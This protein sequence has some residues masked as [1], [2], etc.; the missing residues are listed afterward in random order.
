MAQELMLQGHMAWEAYCEGRFGI[1]VELMEEHLGRH[2]KD[3]S[4][5]VLLGD[6]LSC[7]GRADEARRAYREVAEAAEAIDAFV[8][9][10]G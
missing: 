4:G 6:Y 5:R 2:P 3:L 1:A 10:E 8:V 7:A 9:G